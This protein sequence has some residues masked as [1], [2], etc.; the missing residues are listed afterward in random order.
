[1]SVVRAAINRYPRDMTAKT[2]QLNGRAIDLNDSKPTE[3]L[4]RWLKARQ[5]TGTKEGCGDGDCGACT[6]V[7]LNRDADGQVRYE[8]VNACL[9]PIGALV[10]R[11]VLTV[12]ALADANAL[13]P[14]QQ[15]MLDCGGSQC[16]YCTPGFVMS[17]FA[18]WYAD[19]PLS[20][21][22]I[23]GNLCRCTGYRAIRTATE[24]LNALPRG[25][26]HF[27]AR[28]REGLPVLPA[29]ELGGYFSPL[30]I[31][32]ALALKQQHP[33]A[34]WIAGATDLGVL[35]SR[36]KGT[37][38][39]YIALDRIA[40]LQKIERRSSAIE[41][42]AGVT[43]ARMADELIDHLPVLA[44]LIPW[45]A[46][47]QVRQR[48]TLGGNIGG[49]SPIGDLL[50][51]LLALDADIVL[52]SLEGERVLAMAD[53][54]TGYRQT[55][56]R[57][58]EMI[59][60]VRVPCDTALQTRFYKIAKRQTDDISIV[61]SCFALRLNGEGLVLSARLAFGGVAATPIRLPRVEAA[62]LGKRLSAE[63]VDDIAQQIVA[64]LAPLSDHRASAEYRL[65]L[66][67]NLWRRYVDDLRGM[68][69]SA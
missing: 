60:A 57:D 69:V 28:L 8:S 45:F 58:D 15:A 37:D 5:L 41:I 21:H 16:G 39:R 2:F 46:A 43:L 63:T 53:Y 64:S 22:D 35:L 19:A 54:F 32:E 12:E 61:A 20:D 38:G 9:L 33:D 25:E 10:G 47:K 34:Q 56:R 67:G 18:G 7:L 59:V 52:R 49:A 23:E 51:L 62:L 40:A 6:V 24:Q 3:S 44:D 30:S 31:G 48:A 55:L 29:A 4:M 68:E 66:C 26:D 17:L 36:G 50:P 13:H 11:E 42:G 1:M 27:R 65:A 14:V